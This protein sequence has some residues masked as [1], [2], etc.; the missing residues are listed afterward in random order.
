MHAEPNHDQQANHK[1]PAMNLGK[2]KTITLCAFS[3]VLVASVMFAP[4]SAFAVQIGVGPQDTYD[5]NFLIPIFNPDGSS[6]GGSAQFTT[7]WTG[8]FGLVGSSYDG[9]LPT[10]SALSDGN[11][12][13]LSWTAGSYDPPGNDF[14]L[15]EFLIQY[16]DPSLNVLSF[17]FIEPQAFWS[18]P[19]ANLSFDNGGGTVYGLLYQSPSTYAVTFGDTNL[20][21]SYT[22]NTDDPPCSQCS[23]TITA[24]P[25]NSTPEPGSLLLLGS[26]MVGMAGMVRRKL[27][28]RS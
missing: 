16:E 21:A 17:A 27:G 25:L 13:L 3:A 11:F 18:S 8:A 12:A 15:P 20:G 5:Y 4:V 14:T 1:E 23:I 9:D 24:T 7:I 28:R 19:G 26:G 22:F 10:G 6:A 2:L